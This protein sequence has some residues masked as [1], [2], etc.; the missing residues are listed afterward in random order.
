VSS[1][2]TD[3]GI[4]HYETYGSGRPVILLHGWL[5]SWN[6]WLST[7]EFLRSS[8]RCYAL[9]FWG[10]GESDKSAKR[11][12][13]EVGD[14]VALVYEF[15]DRMGIAAAPLVGHSMGGTVSLMLALKHPERV[16]KAV[17]VGSPIHGS[18]L[19]L[20]LR[21]AG[22]PWIGS[23][24]RSQPRLL[25]FGIKTFAPLVTRQA[26]Q[27]YEM[28]AQDISKTTV[29]S[30][31]A[32]IGSLRRTDLRGAL[33]RLDVPAYGIYGPRDVIVHPGQARVLGAE[34]PRARVVVLDG[35]GHFPMLDEP[36][37]F[38]ATLREFLDDEPT[39]R[40]Q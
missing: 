10:F 6:Y 39:P 19:N 13:F 14:F 17:V 34:A 38:N 3:Q 33:R 40:A 8:Y 32:S 15:M 27:W 1:I 35:S 11:S 31:F 29:E 21:L 20:L 26:Q 4:V 2:V 36:Q 37:R 25:F 30:F 23:I 5:G 24:V 9:D 28:V 22:V 16:R 7:M 12:R 18:S